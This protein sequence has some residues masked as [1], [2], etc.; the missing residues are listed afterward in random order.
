MTLPLHILIT[1]S[2]GFIGS[3]LVERFLGEGHFVTGVDN[4]ISGQ[5]RNTELFLSHPNF[6][7]IEADVSY[8]IPFEGENLDWVMHFASP[9][10]PPHYQQFPI[11]TLMVGAQG[12]QNALEL[13]HGHGAKF[14]LAST[15]E[16]YGDPLMHPQPETYWGNVNPNGVRSCYD[17]AKRYAEAIT[18]AYHRTKGID[19]R[20]IRI[21]NTFG[22]RMRADDGRV[23]TNFI[24]QALSGQP[25]TVYG[26][27][28][29]TRSFQY[30][31]DLVEGIARL[32]GVTY[33]EPIN[34]GN[35]DEYS[36]LHFA[37]IIRDRVNPA[38]NIVFGPMPQDDPK[39]RKPDNTR[40]LQLL[41]WAPKVTLREG[42]ERSLGCVQTTSLP[43]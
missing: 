25:L 39:Q 11:E 4:Y 23:V 19:T 10:S 29:Q 42:L 18:M 16:V 33:H 37:Q 31:D 20:I 34:L 32:M 8:G 12:T 36:I 27:G 38:L 5:K 9:A 17:E 35:P 14:M 26:D 41:G 6:R 24:N 40:A 22:P 28:S 1:G 7:F 13:A 2:A 21:F 30:V 3:H 43:S 15:S